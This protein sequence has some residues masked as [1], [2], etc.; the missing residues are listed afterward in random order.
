VEEFD[1]SRERG[2]VHNLGSTLDTETAS[3]PQPF[4]KEAEALSAERRAAY[5]KWRANLTRGDVRLIN[6]YRSKTKSSKLGRP[7][8]ST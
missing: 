1:P 5:D 2:E 4:E 7:P 8:S 3:F 6:E